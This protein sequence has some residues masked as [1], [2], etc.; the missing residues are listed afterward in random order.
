LS[1]FQISIQAH[2]CKSIF[3]RIP[4]SDFQVI[5][6]GYCYSIERRMDLDLDM[7]ERNRQLLA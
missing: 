3:P 1:L 5:V 7:Q 4:E 2:H 6:F